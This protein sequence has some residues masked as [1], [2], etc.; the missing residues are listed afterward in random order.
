MKNKHFLFAIYVILT[1]SSETC[2]CRENLYSN[3]LLND[4]YTTFEN[5]QL[6]GFFPPM[7]ENILIQACGS[8]KRYN[9]S[10]LHFYVSRTGDST[11]KYS[12]KKLKYY[13]SDEVDVSFPVYGTSSRPE[14]VP[15]SVFRMILPSPGCA[16]LGR[17]DPPGEEV[18]IGI[19]VSMMGVWPLFLIT[20]CLM[21]LFG[22]LVWFIV[23]GNNLYTKFNFLFIS[24]LEKLDVQ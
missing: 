1:F 15:D 23:R 2:K 13:V 14:M 24:S 16:I 8:C 6:D 21:T 17:D 12:E 11:K 3:W 5:G 9:K 20:S 19:I 18:I 4:P 22:M 10:K 7:I